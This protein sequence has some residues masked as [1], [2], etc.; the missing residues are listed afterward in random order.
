MQER[1]ANNLR[2]DV[3][4]QQMY[5]CTFRPATPLGGGL[6]TLVPI[7]ECMLGSPTGHCSSNMHK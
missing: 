7:V 6:L 5:K 3:R 4:Y 2:H 1:A